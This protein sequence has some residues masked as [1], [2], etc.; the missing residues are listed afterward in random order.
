M[1]K[2]SPAIRIGFALLLA[3]AVL[4]AAPAKT[5]K[6][7]SSPAAQRQLESAAA[8]YRTLGEYD[9]TGRIVYTVDY[10]GQNQ[11]TET[12]FRIA[13]GPGGR[14]HEGVSQG[15]QSLHVFADGSQVITTLDAAKQWMRRERRLPAADSLGSQLQAGTPGAWTGAILSEL[16]GLADSVA[17][18]TAKPRETIEVAGAKIPCDVLTVEYAYAPRADASIPGPRTV[19]LA[20]DDGRV[21]RVLTHY[22]QPAGR[23]VE[24]KQTHEMVYERMRFGRP[25]PDSLFTFVAPADWRK[26]RQFQPPGQQQQ[27]DL[28]GQDAADFTLPDLAGS[29]VTLSK[30]RGQVV[31]LDFWA[32][33]CGP[34]RMTMPVVDKLANEFRNSGLVVYSVNL[35]ETPEVA[36]GYL[37]KRGLSVQVLLD[38][39]GAVAQKYM[40]SGI[41]ALIIVGKDGKVAAHMVGAHPE[42]DLRDA[43]SDAGIR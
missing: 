35:R 40:V 3:V 22:T 42:E 2:L 7:K 9:V 31:L 16:R 8:R 19:W 25:A 24:M 26:V 41:P 27:A 37:K 10:Q 28:T 38:A 21:V 5:P 15:G 34:C 6:P 33:W 13:G 23:E 17:S 29:S 32:S 18:V 14:L 20:R 30:L 1:K 4:S 36:E 11:R 12:T 39:D 43:L